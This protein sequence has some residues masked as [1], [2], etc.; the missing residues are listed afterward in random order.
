MTTAT[1]LLDPGRRVQLLAASSGEG[2]I[3]STAQNDDPF[4]F[5]PI[6][7]RTAGKVKGCGRGRPRWV[8]TESASPS[9]QGIS[10]SSFKRKRLAT[11]HDLGACEQGQPVVS[12][13]R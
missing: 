13:K 8:G 1:G 3:A 7:E 11:H 5:M 10:G 9:V 12:G 4:N 2:T 6:I